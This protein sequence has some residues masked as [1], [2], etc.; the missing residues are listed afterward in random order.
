[1]KH[2]T[3]ANTALSLAIL[4]W[5]LAYYGV[6]SQLGDPAPTVPRSEIE[7]AR[8]Q[9]HMVL[10]V[11]ILCLFGSLWLSGYGFPGARVRALVSA[12]LG[13]LPAAAVI[14]SLF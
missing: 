4:A 2:G 14:W 10:L 11:G 3:A 5:P 7:A 6:M 1:M 13:V 12:A 9:S 8:Q